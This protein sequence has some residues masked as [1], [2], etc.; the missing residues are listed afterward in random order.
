MANASAV[1]AVL[2]TN[3]VFVEVDG[4]VRRIAVGDFKDSVDETPSTT[5]GATVTTFTLEGSSSPSFD[6]INRGAAELYQ[7]QMGGYMMLMSGGK[8]YAAKLNPSDWNYFADGTAVDDASLYETMVHVPLCNYL[9]SDKTLYFGGLTPID[10]GHTFDSPQWVGAYK[11]YLDSSNVAHSRPGVAPAHTKT[12]TAF[13]NYAQNLGS[14]WGLANYGFHCLVNALYQARYGNLDSQTV[15]G[16]GFNYSTD[17]AVARDVAMGLTRSLGDGSGCVLYNDDTMGD[18]YPVKLFGFEDL[19]VKLWEFRPG[20]RFY[21]GDDDVRYAVAY[22]GN[23]VSS[24]ATGREISGVASSDSYAKTM[25]LG[26]YWDMVGTSTGGSSSTY[27]CDRWGG[28]TTGTILCVGGLSSS[29]A[30][31]GVAC[32]NS[33][34]A[35]SN[36]AAYFGARLAFYGEPEIVSGT[37]LATMAAS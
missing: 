30:G 27:Y 35:F 25:A 13:W 34:N 7:A 37:E 17:Y 16:Y 23:V 18:Q 14:E 2:D 28:S 24:D 12:M 22:T 11:I 20:I 31:C 4:S 1:S 26:E 29:G 33:N 8:A 21:L 19:W 3:S 5:I 32:S 6:L 36:S 9:G 15:I 10:G